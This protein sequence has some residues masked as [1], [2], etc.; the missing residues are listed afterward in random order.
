MPAAR[1]DGSRK[2]A[3]QAPAEGFPRE[4]ME[5]RMWSNGHMVTAVSGGLR[6]FYMLGFPDADQARHKVD[7]EFPTPDGACVLAPLDEQALVHH[8]V[9]QGAVWL[10]CTIDEKTGKEVTNGF[11]DA[12]GGGRKRIRG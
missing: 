12:R 6:N 5:G 1:F 7:V 8:E 2:K 9:M 11:S 3:E 4:V 10:C